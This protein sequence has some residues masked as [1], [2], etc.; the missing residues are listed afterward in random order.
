MIKGF[1]PN[2]RAA[3]M[4]G[5][6]GPR[7]TCMPRPR[8]MERTM[9]M[10]TVVPLTQADLIHDAAAKRGLSV[11]AFLRELLSQELGVRIETELERSRRVASETAAVQGELGTDPEPA[12]S[13]KARTKTARQ[14]MAAA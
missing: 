1:T 9:L 12:P 6:R 3:A 7:L 4:T 5:A 13:R 8:A 14:K 10:G 11:A 2:R